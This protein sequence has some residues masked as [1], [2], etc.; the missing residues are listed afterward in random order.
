MAPV[1]EHDDHVGGEHCA[2]ALCHRNINLVAEPGQ[3]FAILGETGSVKST[4]VNLINRSYDVIS[5][6][7]ADV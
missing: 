7:P 5:A 1:F 3:V 6:V 4:L 2:H